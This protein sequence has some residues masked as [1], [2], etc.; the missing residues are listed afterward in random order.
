MR[1]PGCFGMLTVTAITAVCCA[2]TDT[3]TGPSRDVEVRCPQFG[4]SSRCVAYCSVGDG[5]DVTGLATWSTGDPAIATVSSTGLVTAR[6]NREVAVRASYR[7]ASGFATVWAVPGQGLHGVSRILAGMVLS[8]EG[9]LS[10]VTM[11][12]LTGPNAGRKM[13]TSSNGRFYM[14]GL[15]D[16][17]F[18]IRLSRAG[19]MA[20]EYLWWIPGGLERTPTLTASS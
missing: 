7:G 20:A 5:Q 1:V 8:L 16:G 17:Q 3:P 10:G 13:T 15:H 12:I 18:T 6:T 4:E 11:E 14:D 2:G 9:P 19:Y